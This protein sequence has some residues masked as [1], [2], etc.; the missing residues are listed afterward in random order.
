MKLLAAILVLCLFLLFAGCTTEE[1]PE[2]A[3]N[4][5]VYGYACNYEG[6]YYSNL[7][8]NPVTQPTPTPTPSPTPSPYVMCSDYLQ[9]TDRYKTVNGFYIVTGNETHT[10]SERNYLNTTIGSYVT[11]RIDCG[12]G[13]FCWKNYDVIGDGIKIVPVSEEES[14][15]RYACKVLP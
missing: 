8:S 11:T 7:T 12:Q 5:L 6:C 14:G 4:G 1:K 2:C 13:Y 10:T 9:V 3:D 15:Y